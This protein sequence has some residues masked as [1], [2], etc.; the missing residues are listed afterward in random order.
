[1]AVLQDMRYKAAACIAKQRV[2]QSWTE[3]SMSG[4]QPAYKEVAS[5]HNMQ[6]Q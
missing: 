2:Q 4:V 1:M 6:A 3:K 5:P